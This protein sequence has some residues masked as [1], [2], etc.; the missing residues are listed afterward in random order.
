MC[1]AKVEFPDGYTL[2]VPNGHILDNRIEG[3]DHIPQD[4]RKELKWESVLGVADGY[5]IAI[6]GKQTG[7]RYNGNYE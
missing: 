2:V 4:D 3:F 6:W 7:R 1:S 5:Q